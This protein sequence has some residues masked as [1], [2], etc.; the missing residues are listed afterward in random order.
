MGF[1]RAVALDLDGTLADHDRV[2][3]AALA[4]VD[5]VRDDGVA[6]VLSTGRI[7]GELDAAF[8]ELAAHLDA[9]VA[10]NGC[11]LRVGRDVRD[12]APAIDAAL[13]RA[14]VRRQVAMRRGRVLL[15]GAGDDAEAVLEELQTLGLDCQL[16]RNRGALMVLPAGVSKGTGLLAALTELG[17]SPHNAVAVGDAENDLALLSVAEIGV[18]VANAVPSMKAHADLVLDAPNGR[19]IA[20]LLRGPVVSG[21]TPLRPQRHRL[22]IGTFDDGSR[23]TVPGA[24]ANVL[25]CGGTGAGKSYL[26]GL[27]AEEWIGAGYSVLIVDM[28]GDYIGL[29]RLHGVTVIAGH[30]GPDA[31]ELL[32]LLRQQSISVVLDLSQL[33]PEAKL[34]YLMRLP[35]LVEAERVAWGMPHWIVIDE[36]QVTLSEQGPATREFR[37]A[38][39][40]YCLVTYRP[41]T[42]SR[43]ALA[44]IDVTVEVLGPGPDG[45]LRAQLRERG[46]PTREFSVGA[47]RT[48]HRRHWHKYAAAAL[49]PERAFEFRRP[50][51]RVTDRATDLV[52]FVGGLESAAP[53]VLAHHLRHGDFS[54]WMTGALQDRGLSAAVAA[55][56]R[57]LLVRQA[58][59]VLRARDAIV[60]AVES[61]YLREKA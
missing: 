16:V 30:D 8:P 19:G 31:R 24:Q 53:D 27:M 20:E 36:A 9:V 13:P 56:E 38:D 59:E 15:A 41:D 14:L 23:T 57:E 17:I 28:E 39:R 52:A 34:D 50:D 48:E 55:V 60:A 18:A 22:P 47:R 1:V 11:V 33:D 26:T 2:S 46:K 37:P 51:G 40:G 7:L 54:R 3:T 49:P 58:A 25:V 35:P 42:L 43:D 45:V 12:L 21:E 10:E 29:E 61:R 32:S 6:V 44:L 5:A 4:A